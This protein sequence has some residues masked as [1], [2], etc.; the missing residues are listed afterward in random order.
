MSE[1][2]FEQILQ[3]F[4]KLF[5]DNKSFHKK[6]KILAKLYKDIFQAAWDG[7]GY[8]NIKVDSK[9]PNFVNTKAKLLWDYTGELLR[10][11]SLLEDEIIVN[12]NSFKDISIQAYQKYQEKNLI[13]IIPPKDGFLYS[14]PASIFLCGEHSVIYGHPAVV[15]P[16][17][18]RLY[19]H[20]KPRKNSRE[21]NIG[22]ILVPNP[23]NPTKK[24]FI[25]SMKTQY[26]SYTKNNHQE[27]L[28]QLYREIIRNYLLEHNG[29]KN[30][31]FDVLIKSDFALACGMNA[32]GAISICIAKA[33][34]D[35]YLDTHAFKSDYS[36]SNLNDEEALIRLAW[37][38]E[39][40]FHNN[41]SSGYGVHTA[42]YGRNGKH[43]IVYSA[44]KRSYLKHRINDGW[45]SIKYKSGKKA[46]EEMSKIKTYVL[47]PCKKNEK[48]LSNAE[49]NKEK[50]YVNAYNYPKPPEFNLS[51]IY[52]GEVT[53]TDIA[54]EGLSSLS[55]FKGSESKSVIKTNKEVTDLFDSDDLHNPSKMHVFEIIKEIYTSRKM[56]NNEREDQL[57]Q[58]YYELFYEIL[59]GISIAM[60]NSV[61]SNWI[62]VPRLMSCSHTIL[63]TMGISY[64]DIDSF[65]ARL[66]LLGLET[67]IAA[68]VTGSGLGGNMIVLSFLPE[69]EHMRLIRDC[70]QGNHVSHFD[71]LISS[72]EEWGSR[73]EGVRP[74]SNW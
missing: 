23:K 17:P 20:I 5:S 56:S 37:A 58:G 50:I 74:E 73:V 52:S 43:P 65:I 68:K 19:L 55:S 27:N 33:L 24:D 9:D 62:L 1:V 67:K 69:K 4:Q 47:D 32:S 10:E 54:I 42:F 28:S 7:L 25:S 44:S 6:N 3:F 16:L 26:K 31:G 57:R 12:K 2:K 36:L 66:N 15:Y 30:Y 45:T 13:E 59:G 61:L 22:K 72:S 38:I 49:E 8:S 11:Q 29:T 40:C 35:N 14:A 60:M 51:I 46:I 41:S 34:F 21:I 39:N 71:F 70:S 63:S 64:S 18:V 48:V 53:P